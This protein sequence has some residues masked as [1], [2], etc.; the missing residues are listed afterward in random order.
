MIIKLN[1]LEEPVV[2]LLTLGTNKLSD[3][4]GGERERGRERERERERVGGREGGGVYA[5][6]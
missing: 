6:H 2:A 4:I 1:D 5:T 3:K